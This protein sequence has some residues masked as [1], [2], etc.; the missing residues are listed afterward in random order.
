MEDQ[1]EVVSVVAVVKG[2]VVEEG[3]E[4]TSTAGTRWTVDDLPTTGRSVTH[5]V[6]GSQG[7]NEANQGVSEANQGVSEVNQGVSEVNQEVSEVNQGVS[8]ASREE[9]LEEIIEGTEEREGD[10]TEGVNHEETT[11]DPGMWITV[12]Q[13]LTAETIIPCGEL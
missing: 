8:E 7:L 11:R 2:A 1:D 4:T 5:G 13:D 3:S 6:R 10:L 12:T 9:T